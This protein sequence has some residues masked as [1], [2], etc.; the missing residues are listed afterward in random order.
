LAENFYCGIFQ[1][2]ETLGTVDKS[3]A[4]LANIEHRR[5]LDVIPVLAGEGVNAGE[6]KVFGKSLFL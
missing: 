4:D 1:L 2:T 5:S 3:L 6:M